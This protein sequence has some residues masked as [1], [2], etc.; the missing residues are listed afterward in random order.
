MPKKKKKKNGLRDRINNW[1]QK[2][3][4]KIGVVMLP[5]RKTERRVVTNYLMTT[6]EESK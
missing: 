1:R 5:D 6:E 2:Q 3:Y 4:L